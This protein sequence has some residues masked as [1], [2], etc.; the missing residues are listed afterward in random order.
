L[1]RDT[2]TP[3]FAFGKLLPAQVAVFLSDGAGFSS[4]VREKSPLGQNAELEAGQQYYSAIGHTCR[5]L[6]VVTAGQPQQSPR[7]TRS[8]MTE[9]YGPVA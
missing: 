6:S 7:L 9:R 8:S 4:T 2:S 3:G 5:H 1:T